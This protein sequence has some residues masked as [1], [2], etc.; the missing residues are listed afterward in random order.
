MSSLTKRALA[1]ATLTTVWVALGC[2]GKVAPI[3]PLTPAKTDAVLAGPL[4][5]G[6]LCKCRE[7][8]KGT[9]VAGEPASGLKR[10]EVRL[11]PAGNDL[12][13]QIG[14]HRIYKSNERPTECFYVDLPVGTHAVTLRGHGDPSFGAA[15]TIKEMGAPHQKGV[16]WYSTFSF[17]C[18]TNVCS[19]EDL[20]EWRRETAKLGNRH[21]P[22]GSTKVNAINYR[23]GSLPDGLHPADLVV[24]AN[25]EI[26]KFTPQK[27]PC[28]SR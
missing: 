13:L 15:F 4:C 7:E 24:E 1:V 20:K 3:P 19:I 17:E 25:L 11:G 16:D 18:G 28:P 23:T 22:C 14:P 12:R 21:D 26:Y 8:V 9:L 2:S 6:A 27:P 5:D 10:F